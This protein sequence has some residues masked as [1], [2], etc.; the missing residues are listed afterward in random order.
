MISVQNAAFQYRDDLIFRN[1]S[2]ELAKGQTAAILGPNGRGKTT[3][4]KSIVGLLPLAQGSVKT[5]GHIG[6][7]AQK[8]HMAF[9][10]KV[11]DIV[12]MGRAAHVGLFRTP[13]LNDYKIARAT[14]DRLG[15]D[16]FADRLYTQL[17]G[18]ERQMVMIARALASE[19]EVLFLDEPTSA[20]DFFNQALILKLLRRIVAEDGLTVLFATHVPQHAQYLADA[21]MLMHSVDH[22]DWGPAEEMLTETN[23]EALYGVPVKSLE[24]EHE[25]KVA[26]NLVPL[27]V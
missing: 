19:C 20:L 1:V 17:S 16:S 27:F 2:F 13:G 15:I 3:L 14:L 18:G 25:G 21:V 22:Q 8:N 10:Y 11:L 9:S 6:Y 23:L 7:V 26:S 24:V 4:L 5:L 12:V